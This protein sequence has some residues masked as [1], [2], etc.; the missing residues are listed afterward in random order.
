MK[1]LVTGS[2][3]QLGNELQRLSSDFAHHTFYFTDIA[4][5]DIC[6]ECAVKQY[7]SENSIELIINCAAYTAVDAAEDHKEICDRLNHLA[8]AH[9]AQTAQ[10]F[11]ASLIHIST[12]YV[13]DGN[14]F[15]PYAETDE[16]FPMSVY[17]STKLDVDMAVMRICT[18]SMIIRTSWLYSTSGTNF[19]KTMIRLGK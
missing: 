9:L 6:N 14:Y 12:D 1:I 18:Q 10:A 16:T 3:G 7:I 15:R 8:A 17:G 11:G 13:F 19:V 5:L 2:K 4:E